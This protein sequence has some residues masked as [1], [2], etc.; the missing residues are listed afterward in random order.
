[1]RDFP[2][3]HDIALETLTEFEG[4][5]NQEARRVFRAWLKYLAKEP[6]KN[7]GKGPSPIRD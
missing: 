6:M 5:Q 1:M 4:V 3:S 2:V 7:V